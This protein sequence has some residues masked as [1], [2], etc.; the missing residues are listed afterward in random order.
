M[1]EDIFHPGGPLARE[2]ARFGGFLHVVSAAV[3]GLVM[4]ALVLALVRRAPVSERG[5]RRGVALATSLTVA[6]LFVFLVYDLSVGRTTGRAPS[7]GRQLTVI[8]HQYWWEVHYNDSF[9]SRQVI[10][11]NEIVVPV[12]EPVRLE[13]QSHDVIHSFWVPSLRGKKDL[14][15]G[16]TATTWFQADTPG[17][18][19]GQCAEFCGHQHAK[20]ALFVTAVSPDSFVSWY[21]GQQAVP[22]APSDSL[23]AEG[24]KVFLTTTCATCH[25][26]AGTPASGTAGPD[27]SHVGSR[28]Y[29][30]AGTLKN[31]PGNMAGWIMD[32]GAYKVGSKMPS[33]Y[34]TLTDRQ[35]RAIAAYLEGLR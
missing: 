31:T 12:G 29:L 28:M 16:H 13:L 33:H 7:R 11:A 1:R 25:N 26:I 14:V 18:Y 4:I 2:V 23:R 27:L 30:A 22:P 15:P 17:I 35:V 20:M 6:T 8:G 32:P 10:T 5:M 34:G 9:P 3:F 19:R 21:K 24:L